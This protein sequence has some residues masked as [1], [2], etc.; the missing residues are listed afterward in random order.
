MKLP[1]NIQQ[2]VRTSLEEDIGAGDVTADLIPLDEASKATILCRD[3]AILCG[4]AWL[5][6]TFRQVDDSV[7]AQWYFKDGD[8]IEKNSVLCRLRGTS[9]SLLSGER[10]A[11]NFYPVTFGDCNGN[12][13]L[14]QGC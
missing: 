14:C 2:S 5:D 13:G 3:D 9:R 4:S 12:S 7:I 1:N 8:A 11:L 6:E 10:V